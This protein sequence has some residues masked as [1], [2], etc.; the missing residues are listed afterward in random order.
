MRPFRLV[1]AVFA[2][3]LAS[4]FAEEEPAYLDDRS[5]VVHLVRSLYNAINRREYARAWDYFGDQKPA[6]DLQAF[7]NGY[8]GTERV[9]IA[10]GDISEEGAAGS[11]FYSV[12]VAIM[13]SGKDG[14]GRVFAGCYTAR[15]PIPQTQDVCEHC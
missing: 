9:E 5:D 6:K 13:A 12:P 8:A 11:I 1:A 2:C 10:T 3:S 14:S 15:M 7:A 4:A